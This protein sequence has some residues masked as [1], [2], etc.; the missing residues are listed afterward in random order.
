[1]FGR[2]R[3][4]SRDKIKA[5]GWNGGRI[6]SSYLLP[7]PGSAPG[8]VKRGIISCIFVRVFVCTCG[9]SERYARYGWIHTRKTGREHGMVWH[10]MAWL[11]SSSPQL[12]A[13]HGVAWLVGRFSM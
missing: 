11:D 3:G 10:G 7:G 1:M 8:L 4:V 5:R 6:G 9:K 12:L 2:N 13:W